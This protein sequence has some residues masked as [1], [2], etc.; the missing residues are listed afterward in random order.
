M[1]W[2]C[3]P[4]LSNGEPLARPL[5]EGLRQIGRATGPH[6]AFLPK[7]S[8]P[9]GG[10]LANATGYVEAS[11]SPALFMRLFHSLLSLPPLC[12]NLFLV[13]CLFLFIFIF[14]ENFVLFLFVDH[15]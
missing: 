6:A 9:Q 4:L 5:Y 3:P 12:L 15:V 2:T 1:S 8:I 7:P 10:G 13:L 11:M 14:R